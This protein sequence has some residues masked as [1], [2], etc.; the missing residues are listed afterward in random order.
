MTEHANQDPIFAA[1]DRHRELSARLAAAMAVSTKLVN[2]PEFEA[3]DTVSG[4]RAEDLK[5]CG[6][7]LIR[8]EP[9]TMAGAIALTRYL[10]GL[11]E[12][13]MPTDDPL[14]EASRDLS[15]DWRRKVL[16]T[17]LANALDKISAKGS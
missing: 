4:A 1:I 12:W 9:A 5:A 8:S 7:S 13:Q 6:A 15:D 11:G 10:A 14:A 17:T 2:G 16:L 3:A